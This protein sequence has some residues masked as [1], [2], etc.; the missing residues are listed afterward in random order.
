MCLEVRPLQYNSL[1][2]HHPPASSG[3]ICFPNIL[4]HYS[5]P[6]NLFILK[7]RG[8]LCMHC[9]LHT[10][11]EFRGQYSLHMFDAQHATLKFTRFTQMQCRKCCNNCFDVYKLLMSNDID[12]P[13]PP[14]PPPPPASWSIYCGD[15][16]Q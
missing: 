1:F 10:F 13:S 8:K 7:S 15:E 6:R 3:D 12:H 5:C 16:K 2:H 9:L 14:P 11:S 4:P